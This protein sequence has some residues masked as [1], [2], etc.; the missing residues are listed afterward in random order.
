M[1][2]LDVDDEKIEAHGFL[3]LFSR[4][5]ILEPVATSW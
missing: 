1:R 2:E 3:L 5:I 4:N